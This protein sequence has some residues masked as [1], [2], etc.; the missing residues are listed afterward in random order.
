M[1][2]F[3]SKDEI[4]A[5]RLVLTLMQKNGRL[6]NVSTIGD[7]VTHTEIPLNLQLCP[8]SPEA[9]LFRSL[10]FAKKVGDAVQQLL[11]RDD[12]ERDCSVTAYLSQTFWKPPKH[13]LGTSAH[14]DNAY[15]E[16][17]NGG[18]VGTAM[19]TAVH[20][21]TIANGT[22]EVFP[23]TGHVLPHVRDGNSDHHITC[24]DSLT[25]SDGVPL[26]LPAGGVAFFS[27]NTPHCTKANRTENARAGIAYHFLRTDHYRDRHFPLPEE[28]QWITPIVAGP[29]STGGV[30]EYGE[31]ADTWDEDVAAALAGR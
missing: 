10:P 4:E 2:E 17:P 14:Q 29:G 18:R 7:G 6:A 1:S 16:V 26:E 13:G 31:L 11:A 24:R 5:M 9:P 12:A 22:L 25:E 3:W 8:L 23:K 27:F 19:W 30:Q 15:F 28:A 21:A 20:D